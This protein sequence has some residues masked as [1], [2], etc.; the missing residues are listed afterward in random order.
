NCQELNTAVT[1]GA[2]PL[3]IV[4]DNGMFGT[5]REHQEQ[6]YPGR[7]S[8]TALENPDFA[9]MARSFGCF[10]ERVERTEDFAPALERALASD[11]AAVLHLLQ[12]P[13]HLSP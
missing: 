9:A 10:G 13:E 6:W 4:F 3:T 11:R 8:G 2:K 1:Y 7:Q 5:I 12:D